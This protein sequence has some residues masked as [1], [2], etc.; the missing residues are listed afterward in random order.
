MFQIIWKDEQG[1]DMYAN[2]LTEHDTK[3]YVDILRTIGVEPVVFRKAEK[4]QT[5]KKRYVKVRFNGG[6]K[7]YTYLCKEKVNVG[8]LVVVW[9]SDGRELV[10]VVEFG[11]ATDAELEAICPLSKFKYISGRVIAA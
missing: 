3:V 6:A 1:R 10:T 11:E 5:E 4:P 2:T 7:L 8:D 9:T